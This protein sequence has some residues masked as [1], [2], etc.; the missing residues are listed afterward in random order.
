[1]RI[2]FVIV[3]AGLLVAC[4]SRLEPEIFASRSDDGDALHA[5][6]HD[7][8]HDQA[9]DHGGPRLRDPHVGHEHAGHAHAGHA[10]DAPR[11]LLRCRLCGGWFDPWV[12]HHDSPRGTPYIHNF[13]IEPAYLGRD[14]IVNYVSEPDESEVEA[15]LELALTRRLGLV[16]EVPYIDGEDDAGV[17]D[18]AIAL[19]ALLCETPDFLLSVSGEIEIPTG[20]EDKDLGRGEVAIAGF[21]HTWMDLGNWVTLQTQ[22]GVEHV[23]E[24]DE[25]E[26]IWRLGLA[27]SWCVCPLFGHRGIPAHDG[28][29]PH[30]VTVMAEVAGVTG[31]A[32]EESGTTG[33]W[34][35]GA[36]YPIIDR[37]ELRAAYFRTFDDEDGWLAGFIFHF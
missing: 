9:H 7:H 21:L 2:G 6:E 28:H 19:R 15:E 12:H 24:E 23:P 13:L 17:G 25:T 29:G 31:L 27:K 30:A 18:A 37:M 16:V 1:M 14:L 33:R 5:H 32:A 20:D 35:L 11:R 34:L 36:S 4:S 22:F 10:H 26:L 8:A 3:V